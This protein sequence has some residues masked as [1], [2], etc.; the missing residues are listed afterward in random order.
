MINVN[1]WSKIYGRS[2]FQMSTSFLIFDTVNCFLLSCSHNSVITFYRFFYVSSANSAY[3][4]SSPPASLNF[5]YYINVSIFSFSQRFSYSSLW[6]YDSM[7]S[8]YRF[9]R[10][11]AL[12]DLSR[13]LFIAFSLAEGLP[14]LPSSEFLFSVCEQLTSFLVSLSTLLGVGSEV[15]NL[16]IRHRIKVWWPKD[17]VTVKYSCMFKPS[18]N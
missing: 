16:T 8:M 17:Q 10:T 12:L 15:S 3:F 4:Y 14:L 5:Y 18:W 6:F 11:R 13:L 9:L 7:S 2:R 1:A